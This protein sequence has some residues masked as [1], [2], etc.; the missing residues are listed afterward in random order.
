MSRESDEGPN[1]G[2][3][4][5]VRGEWGLICPKCGHDD[6]FKV[7]TTIWCWLEAHGSDPSD[8]SHEWDASSDLIC[9]HDGCEWAGLVS[10]AYVEPGEP[11]PPKPDDHPASKFRQFAKPEPDSP[12]D[13]MPGAFKPGEPVPEKPDANGDKLGFV[14]YG[15]SVSNPPWSTL[16]MWEDWRQ[17][18]S[19]GNTKLGYE[20]WIG[21][22]REVKA[23]LEQ[24]EA[25]PFSPDHKFFWWSHSEIGPAVLSGK[26]LS[27]I[28]RVEAVDDMN[29][30]IDG[31]GF[32]IGYI[33][34]GA[35][36]VMAA[37]ALQ[38]H[39]DVVKQWNV[40][41]GVIEML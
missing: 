11:I 40:A 18:V 14:D 9:C 27:R 35:T 41:L 36:V 4:D 26:Q 39:L 7:A 34:G 28:C 10:E 19:E 8:G 6:H 32:W 21:H 22:Q 25:D 30:A 37:W 38:N 17:E 13:V 24:D 3:P 15:H 5:T 12:V 23:M 16:P 20:A 2:P 33:N 1:T 31:Q 29:V